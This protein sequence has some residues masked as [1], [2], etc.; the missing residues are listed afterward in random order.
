MFQV[1]WLQ[2]WIVNLC[3]DTYA[4][5]SPFQPY[6]EQWRQTGRMDTKAV[7]E[8]EFVEAFHVSLHTGEELRSLDDLQ[9]FA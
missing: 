5:T 9:I 8:G 4:Q 3:P 2:F 6:R 7:N 1:Q